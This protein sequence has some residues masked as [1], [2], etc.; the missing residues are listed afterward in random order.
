MGRPVSRRRRATKR[1]PLRASRTALVATTDSRSTLRTRAR[2][3]NVVSARVASVMV[4]A[5]SWPVVKARLPR[6]TISFTRSITSI[7][8]SGV[9]LAITMCTELVPRSMAARR[10]AGMLAGRARPVIGSDRPRQHAGSR[11]RAASTA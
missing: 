11:R 2:R 7:R 3:P 10:T 4:S 6:R 8:P 1:S 9:T 5:D